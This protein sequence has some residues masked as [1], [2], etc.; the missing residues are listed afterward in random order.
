MTN[1]YLVKIVFIILLSSLA[2]AGK[3]PKNL[4]V[5]KF[6]THKETTK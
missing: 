1:K 4:K 5:L 6:K 2:Q 3:E